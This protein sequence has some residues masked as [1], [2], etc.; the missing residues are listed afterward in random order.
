VP[1]R[2]KQHRQQ[3]HWVFFF[4]PQESFFSSRKKKPSPKFVLAGVCHQ[5]KIRKKKNEVPFRLVL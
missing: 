5:L 2:H 3:T 4:F 1:E